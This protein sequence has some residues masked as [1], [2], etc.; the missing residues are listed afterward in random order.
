M[1]LLDSHPLLQAFNHIIDAIRHR[2]NFSKPDFMAGAVTVICIHSSNE[3]LA[4]F[5][6]HPLQVDEVFL[7]LPV[8]RNGINLIVRSLHVKVGHQHAG[9]FIR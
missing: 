5:I 7:A 1:P 9:C 6:N 3:L 4:V 2:D 8:L